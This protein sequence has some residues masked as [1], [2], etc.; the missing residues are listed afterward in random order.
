MR[1]PFATLGKNGPV[2][3]IDKYLLQAQVFQNLAQQESVFDSGFDLAPGL[4]PACAQ[5]WPF[6]RQPVF[7]AGET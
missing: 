2:L 3:F 1:V 4:V 6:E 7:A 5:G